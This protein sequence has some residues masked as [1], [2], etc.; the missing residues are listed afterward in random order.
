MG[1]NLMNQKKVGRVK[2]FKKEKG[3]GFIEL[4]DGK[5]IFFHSSQIAE[6][7]FPGDEVEFVAKESKKGLIAT[8]VKK[9]A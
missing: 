5:D 4:L 6:P 8:E 3:F 2:W 9:I 7:I 1:R